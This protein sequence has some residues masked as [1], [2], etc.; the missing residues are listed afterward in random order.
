L[1][2][3]NATTSKRPQNTL[4]GFVVKSRDHWQAKGLEAKIGVNKLH[5]NV[6]FLER[7]KEHGQSRVQELEQEHSSV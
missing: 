5:N 2:A 4:G 7:T 3:S 6:R 1:E